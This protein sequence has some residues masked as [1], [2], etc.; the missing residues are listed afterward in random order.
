MIV[1]VAKHASSPE[2]EK[3]RLGVTY[4]GAAALPNLIHFVVK[5]SAHRLACVPS[6]SHL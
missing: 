6:Y 3:K 4:L 5:C 1:F 2:E